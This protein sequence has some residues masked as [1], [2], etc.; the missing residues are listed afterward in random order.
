MTIRAVVTIGLWMAAASSPASDGPRLELT[1]GEAVERALANNLEL[2]SQ[3]LARES[4]VLVEKEREGAYEP[5]LSAALLRRSRAQPPADVFT[6]PTAISTDDLTLDG[7]LLKPLRT[8]GRVE[9]RFGNAWTDTTSPFT[10]FNPLV[11]TDVA[12]AFTQPLLRNRGWDANRHE[13]RRARIERQQAELR[14]EQAV[15]DTAAAVSQL[16]YELVFARANLEVQ[17]KSREVALLFLD[18]NRVRMRWGVLA[19]LEITVAEAEVANREAE[20][21][22]AEKA[23]GDTEDA[24]K[25]AISSRREPSIWTVELVPTDLPAAE[26]V[27]VDIESAVSKALDQRPDVRGAIR[28]IEM[29]D[30]DL[31]YAGNQVWPRLDLAAGYGGRGI[32]GTLLLRAPTG[33]VL[34]RSPGGF[35][36]AVSDVFR[37]DF[38]GWDLGLEASYPVV[39]RASRAAAAGAELAREQAEAGLRALKLQVTLEVRRAARAVVTTYKQVQA[40]RAARVLAERRLDVEQSRFRANT[41]TNLEV[42]QTQRDLAVARVAELRAA[43]AHQKS[44]VELD[45]VQGGLFAG[46]NP[47]GNL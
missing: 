31:K 23:L 47:N 9:V 8:G 43:V 2:V 14:F 16:Y 4:S 5:L 40:T 12:V 10:T 1:R 44:L 34:G 19:P 11:L 42:V 3:G 6:G 33:T 26:P 29:A 15:V 18:E 46:Q 35:V 38:P 7:D 24:L 20:V 39:N 37:R 36:D 17:K 30:V 41:A 45:R 28:R 22:R 13:L 21:M 32:G 25:R 27:G